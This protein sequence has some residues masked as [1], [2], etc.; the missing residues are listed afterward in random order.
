MPFFNE[1]GVL[2]HR[3]IAKT[4]AIAGSIQQL[5]GVELQ[6]FSPRNAGVIVQKLEAKEATW[7][8]SKETLVGHGPIAVTTLEN[9]LTGEGFD[10]SVAT[11]LLHIH[12]DFTMTNA[13]AVLTS[14]RATIEL[15]VEKSGE[16]LKVR[17]VK[18]CEA[19]D[20]LHIV[21]QPAAQKKYRFTEAFSDLAVY[22]GQSKVVTLPH[23]TRTKKLDG[24]EGRFNT[25]TFT[26]GDQGKN[27]PTGSHRV[28]RP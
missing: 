20:N 5:Q 18:R 9:R 23:P 25:F 14:D 22:D 16:E 12:R 24:G 28:T 11:S 19:I 1:A 10:F 27:D 26:I 13:E 8:E 6:Y 2:T 15:V 4:G 7:D 3:L 17:D 21:I